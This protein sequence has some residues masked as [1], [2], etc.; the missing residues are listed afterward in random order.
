MSKLIYSV[1]TSLDGYNSDSA[2][3]FD[4]SSPDETVH[5]YINDLERGVGTYLYGRR[6][7]E[8]MVAWESL[9]TSGEPE[10]IQDFARI[11][12]AADKIV[13]STSLRSPSSARTTIVSGFE[14]ETV[15][16]LKRT[17][18]RDI[19]VGGP[20]LAGAALQAGLVDEIH[21][22]VCPVTVGGGTR[23]IPDDLALQLE[24][25]DT[26]SFPMAWST[27]TTPCEQSP[28]L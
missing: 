17:S 12:R 28:S 15:R 22:L 27:C 11:W 3:R 26:H 1:V 10:V 18:D 5:A 4:W 8:V 7:Y 20:M 14:A 21:L 25:L 16:Q 23:W 6:M 9:G 13:F 19:S 2:G 24:L